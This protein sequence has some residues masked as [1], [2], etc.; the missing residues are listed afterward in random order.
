MDRNI[1]DM[2]LNEQIEFFLSTYLNFYEVLGFD[3]KYKLP[4]KKGKKL[5]LWCGESKLDF[6][7]DRDAATQMTFCRE[8]MKDITVM[9]Q[10]RLGRT[11]ANE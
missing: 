6:V 11:T 9:E 7:V 8:S 1:M 5:T 10:K 2:T 4:T 3:Y